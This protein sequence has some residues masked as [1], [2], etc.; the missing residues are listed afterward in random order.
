MRTTGIM[1]RRRGVST[2]LGTLIFIGILFTA[3]IPMMLVM[4]QADTIY[5]QTKLEASRLDE[6]TE[7]EALELYAF[8]RSIS[9][10][11]WINITAY[12]KC[13]VP[14]NLIRLW[15]NDTIIPISTTVQSMGSVNVTTYQINATDGRS[16]EVR[17]TSERGN[18]YVSQ[19]G[20]LSFVEGEWESETLGI[21]LIFP[22]RPGKAKRD[23][24]WKN[25]L[26]ITLT[27][28]DVGGDTLYDNVTMYWAISASEKFFELGAP[29]IYNVTVYIKQ[30]DPSPF[31]VVF[32]PDTI[33]GIPLDLNWPEGPAV[34]NVNF[35]IV[36]T[37][38]APPD[39]EHLEVEE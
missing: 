20:T 2:I 11:K 38:E 22:S 24:D 14:I 18:V 15:V 34:L 31:G 26:K 21:N 16:Y 3:V 5:E 7:R 19:T 6:E 17:A 29:G 8:P 25:E 37:P 13:E 39:E 35:F 4:K 27:E 9:E 10:P 33:N 32:S 36:N 1:C 12:N 23:N 28:N 30:D